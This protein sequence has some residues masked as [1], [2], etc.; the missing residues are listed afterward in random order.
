MSWWSF[1]RAAC[2]S[3]L[4]NSSAMATVSYSGWNTCR[5]SLQPNSCTV[6]ASLANVGICSSQNSFGVGDTVFTGATSPMTM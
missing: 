2:M 6:S 4:A 1:A 5:P 3:P